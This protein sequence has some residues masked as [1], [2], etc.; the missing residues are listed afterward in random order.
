M[1]AL[2]AGTRDN[3]RSAP[4]LNC[5]RLAGIKD[6]LS[7]HIFVMGVVVVFQLANDLERIDRFSRADGQH[8]P[9]AC[10]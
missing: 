4:R 3:V 6:G 8:R 5:A 9:Y 1:K 10:V 2:A 7:P